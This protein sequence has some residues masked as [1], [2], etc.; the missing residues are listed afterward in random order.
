MAS[1][2]LTGA[3][4]FV[5]SHIFEALA[6]QNHDIVGVDNLSAGKIDFVA[7]AL[8]QHKNAVLWVM[9]FA[10]V[11]LLKMI[12]E[13]KFD[14]IIHC[15]AIP[16]IGY[17]IKE[18]LITCETNIVKT[19][20]LIEAVRRA[21]QK[22]FSPVFLFASSSSI[23]GSQKQLP[24]TE[25]AIPDIRSPY[26]HQKYFIEQHLKLCHDL[27]GINSLSLRFFSVFGPRSLGTSSYATVVGSWLTSIMSEKPIVIHGTG[28]QSRDFCY[29]G[30]IVN[31]I[32]AAVD[33]ATKDPNK[34]SAQIL[35]VACGRS[36][37]L[38]Q[39]KEA[40][41]KRFTFET[42]FVDMRQADIHETL[43]D[44]SA[45]KHLLGY[46]PKVDFWDGLNTTID[47]YV[48]NWN[49]IKTL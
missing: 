8:K 23:Y 12:E 27:Y 3:A 19:Y 40:L 47:W 49:W 48:D 4:G 32:T 31:A 26:A 20:D 45:A 6:A 21:H 38:L 29:V 22:H 18:P 15:A 10:D 43:A 35:N 44:V 24:M 13:E 37:N 16:R 11:S 28:E 42:V 41:T 14:L 5:G 46:E 9:D 17:S 30:N 25:T 2:L 39:I 36:Y 7:S 1:I 34:L 33:T